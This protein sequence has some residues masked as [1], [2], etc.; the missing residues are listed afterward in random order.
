VREAAPDVEEKAAPL[1]AI[2]RTAPPSK[3][4]APSRW[5]ATGVLSTRHNALFALFAIGMFLR[6]AM[7]WVNHPLNAYDD[8]YAPIGAILL[9]GALPAKLACPQCYHPPVFYVLSAG[10]AKMLLASGVSGEPLLKTLQAASCAAGVATLWFVLLILRRLPVSPFATTVAFAFVCLL[11]R[12][13][14]MSAIH[15]NDSVSYL[16]IT[17]CVYILIRVVEGQRTWPWIVGLSCAVAA[18]I[19]TKFTGLIVVPVVALTLA[20][21]TRAPLRLPWRNAAAIGVA[22]LGLPLLLLGADIAA[23]VDR[24]G[25]PI[26]H[27]GALYSGRPQPRD[28]VHPNFLSFEP[29]R[30][31]REPIIRPGQVSSFLTLLHAGMWFDIDARF[32]PY[33]SGNSRW[34]DSYFAWSRGDAPYPD[35]ADATIRPI[36]RLGSALELAGVAWLAVAFAGVWGT[37]RTIAAAPREG[38]ANAARL[39]VFPILIALNV[40][41]VAHWSVQIPAFTYSSMKASFLLGSISPM[42][43]LVAVGVATIEHRRWARITVT[44]ATLAYGA[45][46]VRHVIEFVRLARF[47]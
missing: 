41:G 13:I 40:A 44:A 9:D 15:S 27:T 18:S 30:F 19:F 5:Y 36:M 3:A 26:P 34:W 17:V 42:G 22:V 31:V 35:G 29:W 28:A 45:L 20:L 23:N 4:V 8:H 33:V 39:Q 46:V 2:E 37:A 6:V 43:S 11:P 32:L 25:T 1:R 38:W 7:F 10:L 24:Y 16:A 12:H 21:L 14:Y 47:S